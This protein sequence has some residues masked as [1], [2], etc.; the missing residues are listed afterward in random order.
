MCNGK[1]ARR[2]AQI[3]VTVHIGRFVFRDGITRQF[4]RRAA[5]HHQLDFF[6]CQR[7]IVDPSIVEHA[8][9]EA[10]RRLGVLAQGD[11]VRGRADGSR[12]G[13]RCGHLAIEVKQQFIAIEGAGHV[14]PLP[15]QGVQVRRILGRVPIAIIDEEL[16]EVAGLMLGRGALAD[17][18]LFQRIRGV[19]P[20]EVDEIQRRRE[21]FELLTDLLSRYLVRFCGE[22]QALM[23]LKDLLNFIPDD[24]LQRDMGKLKR[25]TTAARFS[26][27]LESKFSV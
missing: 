23:K 19:L 4:R 25:A 6:L 17:P 9:E 1:L 15:D 2:P 21:L 11:V 27:L 18:W 14:V 20:G 26:A 12:E 8:V 10:A 13:Q 22:R 5:Q 7:A 3:V 16:E 24:C